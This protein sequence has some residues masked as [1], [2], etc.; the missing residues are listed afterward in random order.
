M[1]SLRDATADDLPWVVEFLQDFGA[2]MVI[3][4]KKFHDLRKASTI[5]AEDGTQRVGAI[6]FEPEESAVKGLVIRSASRQSG[7]GRALM[8]AMVDR[9][10]LLRA[11]R[12]YFTTTNDN[13]PAQA[14]HE[15][16]GFTMVRREVGG[17]AEVMRMMGHDPATSTM[18][19]YQDQPIMDILHYEL[20]LRPG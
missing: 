5:I 7:V 15:S 10:R 20:R 12:I 11:R 1:V 14:L 3:C 9:A 6:C 2:P 8:L 13:L 4:G 17:F 18:L 19:G 16:V